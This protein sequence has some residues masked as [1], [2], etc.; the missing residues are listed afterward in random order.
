MKRTLKETRT[1]A[2]T[3][4]RIIVWLFKENRYCNTMT[5]AQYQITWQQNEIKNGQCII[6][7][8]FKTLLKS[9]IYTYIVC[10]ILCI[11]HIS[12]EVKKK[13]ILRNPLTFLQTN[14][15]WFIRKLSICY[16]NY[17]K[18][19]NMDHFITQYIEI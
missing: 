17:Y 11:W 10:S 12:N 15:S 18:A 1:K 19:K 14:I 4:Q 6:F 3:A 2:H 7:I 16:V 5:I 13:H 8:I 9:D